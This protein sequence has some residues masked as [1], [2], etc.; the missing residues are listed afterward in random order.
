MWRRIATTSQSCDVCEERAEFV[1]VLSGQRPWQPDTA[2]ALNDGNLDYQ[3][4]ATFLELRCS[5]HAPAAVAA[6]EP[7]P[8]NPNW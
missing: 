7:D 1:H 2:T 4:P 3:V 5:F 6:L 8:K